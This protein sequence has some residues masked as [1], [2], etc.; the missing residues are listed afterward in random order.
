MSEHFHVTPHIIAAKPNKSWL[1][2][3]SAFVA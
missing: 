3:N 1:L 2:R